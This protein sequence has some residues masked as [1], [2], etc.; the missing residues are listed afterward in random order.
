M[1][2]ITIT[3]YILLP[4]YLALVFVISLFHRKYYCRE[5]DRKYYFKALGL[6]VFGAI[7]TGLIY[8]FVYGSGD[9]ANYFEGGKGMTHLLFSDFD[10]WLVFMGAEN[11][12]ALAPN[13]QFHVFLDAQ[14]FLIQKIVSVLNIFTFSTYLNSCLFF[15]L[16][17]FWCFWALFNTLNSIY[18]S[19]YKNIFAVSLFFIPSVFFWGSGIFKD[20]LCI[21]SLAL[22]FSCFLRL[23]YKKEYR[24]FILLGLLLCASLIILIKIKVYIFICLMFSLGILLFLK[25]FSVFKSRFLNLI[26]TFS[27]TLLILLVLFMS[28]SYVTEFIE[29]NSVENLTKTAKITY[30][31]IQ[32]V[33]DV[34]GGSSYD[35][36]EIDYTDPLSLL[37]KIPDALNVTLFRPYLW[38]SRKV[39]ILISSLES[40]A[41]LILTIFVLFKVGLRR[42]FV[43]LFQNKIILF[44][45]LFALPFAIAVGFSTGNFG[46]LVRYKIPCLPFYLMSILFIY[47]NYSVS[48]VAKNLAV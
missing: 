7:M 37:S 47:K 44:F 30:E 6:K 8:Q 18:S 42:F 27:F 48:K 38:E 19:Q 23:F 4:F 17:S 45:L 2:F 1:Q 36:G 31:Y 32:S 29:V 22:F 33:S 15:A 9:T 14:S 41:L 16:F 34:D 26:F 25:S 46:T 43:I 12:M 13:V 39:L 28:R 21:A 20:T 40:F 24:R 3:D 35:L 10:Q 11:G 5:E